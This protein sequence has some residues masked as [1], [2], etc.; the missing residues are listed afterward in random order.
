M[1]HELIVTWESTTELVKELISDHPEDC[2]TLRAL[3]S[4]VG[5]PEAPKTLYEYAR[6]V[7]FSGPSRG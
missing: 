5:D 2:P 6:D 1:V 3:V 4:R 7:E